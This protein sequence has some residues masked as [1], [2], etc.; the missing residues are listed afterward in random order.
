MNLRA[1]ILGATGAV[2]QTFVRL[3]AEHPWFE[4]TVLG[5]SERSAGQSYRAATNWL[6]ET[7]MPEP[8]AEATVQDCTPEAFADCD[9]VFSGLDSSVA[10]DIERRFAEA[11]FPVISNA[12]NYRMQADVPLLVPEVNADH[13]ALIERQSWGDAGREDDAANGFVVTNPN[14]STVGLVCALAPLEEAF[15]LEAVQV[16]TMQALSGAGYP[17]VSA[18]DALG[19]ALPYIG[20]EEEKMASE[21]HKILGTLVDGRE[22]TPARFAVSAQCNRVAVIDGHLEAVSLRLKEQAAPEEVKEALRSFRPATAGLDLP[23]AP[24]HFLHVFEEEHFPQPRRHA[25]MGGGM[26][27]SVG[28]V[29]ECA[30]LDVKM[31]VLSHNTVRGAAGGAIL[32]AEF[33]A[34]EGYLKPRRTPATA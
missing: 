19:N 20:G 12:K 31:V 11:G 17:G 30:V 24:E 6:A 2:G 22:I 8:V 16:V 29:R 26:T 23:S 1:G 9:F 10:G 33:L 13:A 27:V 34:K 7:P 14:C 5:A 4:L 25:G 32:N 21:P 28:R 15:G 3:L 18:L